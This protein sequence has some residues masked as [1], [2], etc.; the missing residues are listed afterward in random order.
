MKKARFYE[1]EWL[2]VILVVIVFSLVWFARANRKTHDAVSL[3]NSEVADLAIQKE[4]P[5]N[6]IGN[7]NNGGSFFYQNSTLY[8][9]LLPNTEGSGY[10]YLAKEDDKGTHILYDD[11]DASNIVVYEGFLYFINSVD[12]ILYDNPCRHYNGGI[13]RIE[14][15][16]GKTQELTSDSVVCFYIFQDAIFYQSGVQSNGE[17]STSIYKMDLNGE[18]C[19]GVYNY[20]G[21]DALSCLFS[22]YGDAI[23]YATESGD[24]VKQSLDGGRIRNFSPV[25]KRKYPNIIRILDMIPYNNYIFFR[26]V[27]WTENGNKTMLYRLDMDCEEVVVFFEGQVTGFT[28]ENDAVYLS[29]PDGIY[30]LFVESGVST[31]LVDGIYSNPEIVNKKIFA[32]IQYNHGG[33]TSF[34]SI[35]IN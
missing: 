6:N 16:S 2:G 22:I 14:L 27:T 34:E 35:N 28:M 31:K 23:Y 1:V 11:G 24:I 9:R 33:E 7:T 29:S 19:V 8:G 21:G 4:M 18:N 17:L 12:N 30:L 20:S 25:V 10:F 32:L 26:A 3:T 13:W 15:S 5:I